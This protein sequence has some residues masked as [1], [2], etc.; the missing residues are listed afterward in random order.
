MPSND[1]VY[2]SQNQVHHV[3]LCI[4]NVTPCVN[5]DFLPHGCTGYLHALRAF[6]DD[7]IYRVSADDVK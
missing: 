6:N 7:I 2:E 3:S 4:S 1:A 5:I